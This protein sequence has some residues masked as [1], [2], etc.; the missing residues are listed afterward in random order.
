MLV[1]GYYH[2]LILAKS[3]W[4]QEDNERVIIKCQNHKYGAS[5]DIPVA[6]RLVRATK[7]VLVT[8]SNVIEMK[9]KTNTLLEPFAQRF[10]KEH[11]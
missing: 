11:N 8:H 2:C 7:L 5:G 1:E 4:I 6:S 3:A 9:I 10:R